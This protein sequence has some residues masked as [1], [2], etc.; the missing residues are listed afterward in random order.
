M[1]AGLLYKAPILEDLRPNSRFIVDV[2]A[3]TLARLTR[4]RLRCLVATKVTI[5]QY[6][7]IVEPGDFGQDAPF[8]TADGRNHTDVCKTDA[9]YRRVLDDI[10]ECVG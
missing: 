2:E 4:G 5:G 3:G 6:E 9:R 1:R 8:H 7:N 10:E